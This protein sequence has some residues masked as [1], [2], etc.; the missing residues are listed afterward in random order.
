[1]NKETYEAQKTFSG[2]KKASML[3]RC[4]GHDYTNRQIYMLLILAPWEHHNER[5]AISRSQ[6]LSLNDMAKILCETNQKQ[7]EI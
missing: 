4:V 6:C 1:M 2:E 5:K 7:N 3:R